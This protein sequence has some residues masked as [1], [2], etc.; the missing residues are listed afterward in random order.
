MLIVSLKI[1][2]KKCKMAKQ[3]I[4]WPFCIVARPVVRAYSTTTRRAAG[5]PL[6]GI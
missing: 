1:K 4:A 3:E 6:A 2:H 5:V